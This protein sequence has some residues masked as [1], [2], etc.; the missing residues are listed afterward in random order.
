MKN[1]QI[2]QLKKE[3][4]R[5]KEQDKKRLKEDLNEYEHTLTK[6]NDQ[7]ELINSDDYMGSGQFEK[8][9]VKFNC[10]QIKSKK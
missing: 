1:V 5:L 4:N 10:L 9:K 2:S 8:S 6:I 7:I 3:R